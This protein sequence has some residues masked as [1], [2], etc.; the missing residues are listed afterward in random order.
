MSRRATG[1][2]ASGSADMRPCVAQRYTYVLA[3]RFLRAFEYIQFAAGIPCSIKPP[4]AES[5]PG[6]PPRSGPLGVQPDEKCC[7][8][9]L[10]PSEVQPSAFTDFQNKRPHARDALRPSFADRSPSTNAEGD[11]VRLS[12]SRGGDLSAA[13]DEIGNGCH[14]AYR[15]EV[16]PP[17]SGSEEQEATQ[18]L[19][20]A[21]EI[22]RTPLTYRKMDQAGA[23]YNLQD[24]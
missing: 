20:G 8:C 2:S 3:D 4:P 10:I 23:R 22:K 9:R 5:G 13:L 7:P 12:A 1:V 6:A 24:F 19:P 21:A 14:Y 15:Q 16:R 17:T 11:R 18:A